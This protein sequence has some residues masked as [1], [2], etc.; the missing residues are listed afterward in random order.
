MTGDQNYSV[1]L[2]E[3]QTYDIVFPSAP[4]GS[5][6]QMV[7]RYTWNLDD[8]LT[9]DIFSDYKPENYSGWVTGA[10]IRIVT[11][12]D[13]TAEADEYFQYVY[14]LAWQSG[15]HAAYGDATYVW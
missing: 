10:S 8:G 6:N 2:Y 4:A 14:D 11:Y 15:E 3:G 5:Y 12:G 9:A 13:S 7:Y 1:T